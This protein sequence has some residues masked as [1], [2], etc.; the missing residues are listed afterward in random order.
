[1]ARPRKVVDN[2]AEIPAE[3]GTPAEGEAPAE[4]ADPADDF[5][6]ATLGTEGFAAYLR[7]QAVV[8]LREVLFGETP[9]DAAAY[10]GATIEKLL[11]YT[12]APA[13]DA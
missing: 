12:G 1:M 9:A 5:L 7:G 3:E 6:I 2:T 13:G 10:L 4:G 11:A 8:Q